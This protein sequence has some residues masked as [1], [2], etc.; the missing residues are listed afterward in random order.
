MCFGR[1][2]D[3]KWTSFGVPCPTCRGAGKI[4]VPDH[5][6]KLV[7]GS[8]SD[9]LKGARGGNIDQ[10]RESVGRIRNAMPRPSRRIGEILDELIRAQTEAELM[11]SPS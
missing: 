2:I 7:N 1:I 8:L 5:V 10:V 4:N 3:G 9:A 6:A 11:T